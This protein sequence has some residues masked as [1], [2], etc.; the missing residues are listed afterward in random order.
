MFHDA[1]VRAG[2]LHIQDGEFHA[3]EN[4]LQNAGLVPKP[5][6]PPVDRAAKMI[7]NATVRAVRRVVGSFR[8]SAS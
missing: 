2:E 5:A 6:V 7:Y 4:A 8:S 1:D 3:V